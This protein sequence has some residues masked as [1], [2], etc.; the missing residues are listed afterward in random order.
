MKAPKFHR[1]NRSGDK[2][3]ANYRVRYWVEGVEYK[4][5][6]GRTIADYKAKVQDLERK[7][8]RDEWKPPVKGEA[9]EGLTF[10]QWAPQ[11]IAK[12][13]AK[14]VKTADKDERGIVN[15]HLIPEFGSE[16]LTD[17]A[18]FTRVI[19]GFARIR[20]RVRAGAT[21]RN[22]HV[23][24][25]AVMRL[26]A[27]EGLIATAPPLL[28]VQDDEL[29]PVVCMKPEGWR[30]K[31]KFSR[32]EIAQLV[33]C[34]EVELQFRILYVVYFLVGAR[35]SEVIQVRWR[36]WD[37]DRVP[38]GSLILRAAKTPRH[39][40]P[41]YRLVPVHAALHA[42]LTWW[43]REGFELVH[44]RAPQADDLMFPTSSPARLK[45]G[46]EACGYNEV[47]G[48]WARRHLPAAGLRHR[49]LHDARGTFISIIRSAGATGEVVRL[50]THRAV[51]DKVL[52]EGYTVFEWE[53]VCGAVS[54]VDW[55][56]PG[57]PSSRAQVV[58]ISARARAAARQQRASGS[59]RFALKPA[60][61]PAQR[62]RKPLFLA[63]N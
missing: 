36:D 59:G 28:T 38:L 1:E 15:N 41:M 42:W 8:R 25:A 61:R 11:A 44:C 22:I 46:L 16:L 21:V 50:I 58:N 26:A 47:Y 4:E 29:P 34:E 24:F 19:E 12:R 56:L 27:K 3:R 53:L 35:Y 62:L 2:R 20:E 13:V 63:G 49:R 10:A 40:G 54:R 43:H 9:G 6:A 48:R 18:V 45:R 57:P 17:C 51:T 30:A 60:H 52:D 7:F 33:S 5:A 32:E 39:Q 37:R 31:A 14:G 23:V 55:R